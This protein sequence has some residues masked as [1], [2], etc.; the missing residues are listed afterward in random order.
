MGAIYGLI[1]R[2]G[3]IYGFITA[4]GL[5]Y[6]FF[7]IIGALTFLYTVENFSRRSSVCRYSEFHAA[8][9]LQ[10]TVKNPFKFCHLSRGPR[11][12]IIQLCGRPDDTCITFFYA[13]EIFEMQIWFLWRHFETSSFLLFRKFL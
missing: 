9:D 7:T 13:R 6:G 11:C 4:M 12:G 8:R 10:A 1:T 5:L 2:K 3:A